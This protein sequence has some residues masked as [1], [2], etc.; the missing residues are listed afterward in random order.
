[1]YKFSFHLGIEYLRHNVE[2]LKLVILKI[3]EFLI[4]LDGG[5]VFDAGV[6]NK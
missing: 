3:G 5:I 6:G 2:K 1:M 4:S